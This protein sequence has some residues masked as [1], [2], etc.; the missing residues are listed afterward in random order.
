ML[1]KRFDQSDRG[2]AILKAMGQSAGRMEALINDIA[3]V[4]RG[5]LGG[6]LV[7][8]KTI[9]GLE[10]SLLH[11]IDELRVAHPGRD[12][13]ATV[14]L[15][16]PVF[17]DPAYLARLLSNLLKNALTYGSEQSPVNV[18]IAS[19]RDFVMSVTN[20]GDPIPPEAQEK[21]FAPFTRGAANRS[22]QKGLGLGLYIVSEIARAHLGVIELIS[23]EDFT[24]F[25]FR[26]PLPDAQ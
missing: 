22:D 15:A 4:T 3:D 17:G 20:R 25:T 10:A 26:M 12:I 11:A 19:D 13:E 6:G 5:R 18:S 2:M 1:L 14:N 24:R 21:L 23:N 7:L 8:N 9:D 16:R